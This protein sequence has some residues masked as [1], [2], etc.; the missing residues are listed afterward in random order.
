[1]SLDISIEQK[2]ELLTKDNQTISVDKNNAKLSG[3][4]TTSME[5]DQEQ[6]TFNV[7]ICYST[8]RK[9]I[10]YLEYHSVN[11]PTPEIPKPVPDKGLSGIINEWDLNFVNIDRPQLIDVVNASNYLDIKPLVELSCAQIAFNLKGKTNEEIS[12]YLLG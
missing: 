6:V 4:L 12:Q 1:M 9:I 5:L 7:D 2:I 11:P 8:L 10:D 3:L